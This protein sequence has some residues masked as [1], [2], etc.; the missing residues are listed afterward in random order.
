MDPATWAHFASVGAQLIAYGGNVGAMQADG[1][2]L[3]VF[4]VRE[5]TLELMAAA[6]A[7]I[8]GN[9][10]YPQLVVAIS[11]MEDGELV[12][13]WAAE[14]QADLGGLPVFTYAVPREVLKV[15]ARDGQ[16]DAA[17]MQQLSFTLPPKASAERR[18]AMLQYI[19]GLAAAKPDKVTKKDAF[20]LGIILALALV[21]A[22]EGVRHRR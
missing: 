6:P 9:I 7:A 4:K 18:A 20:G 5:A 19:D 3:G 17:A 13:L 22:S 8:A 2:T 12:Q 11:M 21:V 15:E 14:K 10:S 16:W 1:S